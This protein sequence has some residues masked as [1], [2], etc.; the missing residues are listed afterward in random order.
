[1]SNFLVTEKDNLEYLYIYCNHSKKEIIKFFGYSMTTL[2]RRL[3][4]FNIKK[5]EYL[6]FERKKIGCLINLGVD[7]PLKSEKVK[8][9]LKETNLIKYNCENV[10][11]NEKI[12]EKSKNTCNIRYGKD[13][14]T[15]TDEYKERVI[16]T[17]NI[18]YGCDYVLQNEEVKSKGRKTVKT[19]YDVDHVMQCES[20]REKQRISTKKNK[21]NIRSNVEEQIEKLLHLKFNNVKIQYYNKEKYPFNC[22]F[23]I[24]DI[25][26]YIEYQGYW[27]HGKELGPYIKTNKAHNKV[28]K[29]W[30]KQASLGKVGYSDAIKVW[31]VRDPLKRETAKKNGLNWIEFFTFNEFMNW[32]NSI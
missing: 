15:Q 28:L 3:K 24:V 26:T 29:K 16:K 17:N 22:D 14:Y 19:R 21:T 11:Q 23:Y 20:I 25:D 2:S 27:S 9:K 31:T 18:V 6:A 5:P 32:Y 7:N 1:M 12:K 4:S 30:K 10:F 13:Y 8:N